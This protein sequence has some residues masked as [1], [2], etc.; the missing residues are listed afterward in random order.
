[1]SCYEDLLRRRILVFP[2]TPPPGIEAGEKREA[3]CLEFVKLSLIISG[4][5]LKIFLPE[6]TTVEVEITPFQGQPL[7]KLDLL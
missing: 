2:P 5:S 1:L 3:K 6:R 7:N 4:T